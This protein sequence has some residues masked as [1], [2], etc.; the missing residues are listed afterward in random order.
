VIESTVLGEIINLITNG[1]TTVPQLARATNDLGRS[2]SPSLWVDDS[3]LDAQHGRKVFIEEAKAVLQLKQL[4]NRKQTAIPDSVLQGWIT[5]LVMADQI[6]AS[7]QIQVAASANPNNNG[8]ASA[9]K[10][11][12]AS[13][14]AANKKQYS[15][16]ILHY[17]VAWRRAARLA[18]RPL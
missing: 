10:A 7:T 15:E 1:T 11:L 2:L 16:A 18:G 17:A 14:R 13:D 5:R 3:H 12:D 6:L 4:M 8:L 9:Q